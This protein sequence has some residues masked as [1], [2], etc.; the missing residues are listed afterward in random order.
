MPGVGIIGPGLAASAVGVDTVFPTMRGLQC[1]L[2]AAP[3]RAE[4]SSL[5][6]R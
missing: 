4:V 1:L 3:I 6:Q 2:K 5:P